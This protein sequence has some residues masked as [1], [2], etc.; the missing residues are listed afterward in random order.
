MVIPMNSMRITCFFFIF[1]AVLVSGYTIKRNSGSF[2]DED[3]DDHKEDSDGIPGLE[4]KGKSK[5]FDTN[6]T[7]TSQTPPEGKQM[8]DVLLDDDDDDD[9][10]ASSTTLLLS[11][12]HQRTSENEKSRPV[13]PAPTLP[14][15]DILNRNQTQEWKGWMMICFMAYRLSNA[16]SLQ[17]LSGGGMETIEEGYHN[18]YINLSRTI[19]T[20][21]VWLTGYSH[22]QYFY[23]HNDYSSVRVMRILWRINFLAFF[24]CLTHG[25][26]YILYFIC[27]L[28]SYFFI[29]VYVIMRINK[30][31]N[32]DKYKLRVKLLGVAC[33]IYVIWDVD[34]GLFKLLHL[35]F[36]TAGPSEVGATSG[37]MWEWYFRTFMDHWT[38]FFGII[39]AANA[40][41][42]SLF[43]RKLEAQHTLQAKFLGKFTIGAALLGVVA[44][45][46]YGPLQT[47]VLEY[48]ST[49]SYFGFIPVLAYVYFRNLTVSFRQ[50]TLQLFYFF[51]EA[52]LE[53]YLIHHHILF[54]SDGSTML[55]ILPGYPMMNL[56]IILIF[57]LLASR[58]LFSLTRDIS[59]MLLPNNQVRCGRTYGFTAIV[60]ASFYALSSALERLEMMNMGTIAV[61]S[62]I[63]GILLY[64]TI[65]DVSWKTYR[66]S[67]PENLEENAVAVNI[68]MH[69]KLDAPPVSMYMDDENPVA[70]LSPPLIGTFI[71]FLLGLC[72]HSMALTGAGIVESLPPNCAIYANNGEWIPINVCSE[73][74]KGILE[75]DYAVSSYGHFCEAGADTE[76]LLVWG[77]KQTDSKSLCRL[78][79][80]DVDKMQEQ[81]NHR[82]V[83]FIG[84]SMVR[85]FYHAVCRMLGENNAGIYDS[86][87][88]KHSDIT[89]IF[90]ST[91]L[92]YKW[93]P[94]A[95]DELE[96]LRDYK[97][98]PEAS[99]PDLIFLG[100]GAWDRLH[101]WAT[102]EDQ[103]SLKVAVRKLAQELDSMKTR[104][105]PSVWMTPTTINTNALNHEEKRSQMSEE[106][107][108]EMRQLYAEL[109]VL[110]SASFVLDGES[111]TQDRVDESFDGIHYPPQIYDAGAQILANA[112][113]WVLPT[114]Y[115]I[116]LFYP[117]EPGTMA[118]MSLGLMMFCFAVIG[119]FFFDA[120]LGFS[121]LASVFVND[122]M[123]SDLYDETF[124]AL[125]SK[126]KIP[127]V[128][129]KDKRK[130]RG[131]SKKRAEYED[132]MMA[133]ANRS[134]GD[135]DLTV[136]LHDR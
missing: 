7:G 111:F 26:D 16:A 49:H 136:E 48:S 92:E 106:A 114:R 96:K 85:N 21:F 60:V 90:G 50:N 32:Y 81:L 97:K 69:S 4:M 45:W 118:N 39:F 58:Q 121:Y 115:Q 52:T 61:V 57:Y 13:V 34:S 94:L 65:I 18:I 6:S 37:P 72:W 82:H 100:G 23:R 131:R 129:L 42:S 40:P 24:L 89:K 55:T 119:L 130:G 41:I 25:V 19:I 117:P 9:L 27:P 15:D 93:A 8:E 103:E 17:T 112:M 30:E 101:V 62:I 46:V 86:A 80:F 99:A 33:L 47:S 110:A 20:C 126:M 135:L 75:R 53:A 66:D 56:L 36:F 77:W 73:V 79:S 68:G 12:H 70:K 35:P 29:M 64:Q 124:A 44:V 88:P 63:C 2:N 98:V 127:G 104:G 102:D 10:I 71:V 51:G 108:Q 109:G 11:N 91:R 76:Q 105:I 22:F 83:V 78:K 67:A 14:C 132:E 87:I 120:F 59:V 122:V 123:P 116:E 28:Q 128:S 125:H 38:A 95:V 113:D 5:S 84:D 133:F 3:H 134:R 1:L 43:L 54:T 74:E 31:F 107:L